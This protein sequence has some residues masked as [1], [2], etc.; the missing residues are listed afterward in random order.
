MCP[1]HLS[2]HP[3]PALDRVP[4]WLDVPPNSDIPPPV[5]TL[6]ASLPVSAL[7]WQDF[8]RLCVRLA[9]LQSDV[10]GAQLYG[11]AGQAQEGI[12][13]YARFGAPERYRVYQC[14]RVK[15]LEP[16]VIVS[17]VDCFLDGHSGLYWDSDL[18]AWCPLAAIDPEEELKPWVPESQEAMF[19]D[20]Q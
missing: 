15:S 4:T 11:S 17:A 3:T 6:D 7:S 13:L 8:E 1:S 2:K 5:D 16:A 20:A 14:K 10:V 19:A 12:D 18:E 9:R